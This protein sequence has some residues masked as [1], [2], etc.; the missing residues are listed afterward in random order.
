M[1]IDDGVVGRTEVVATEGVCQGVL[2]TRY[3]ADLDLKLVFRCV[4]PYL[5]GA[6]QQE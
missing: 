1:V 3:V 6:R 2:L 5:T 4:T